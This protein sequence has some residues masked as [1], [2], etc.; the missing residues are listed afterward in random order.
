M[1]S[2]QEYSQLYEVQEQA[3][4]RHICRVDDYRFPLKIKMVASIASS[5]IAQKQEKKNIDLVVHWVERYMK[6]H[7][8]VAS[9]MASSLDR[10]RIAAN[11]PEVI[12]K[13]CAVVQRTIYKHKI[14]P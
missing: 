2:Y 13:F 5:V 14:P 10:Q 3:W 6:C 9:R 7:S 12:K 11:D 8:A 1:D 4:K